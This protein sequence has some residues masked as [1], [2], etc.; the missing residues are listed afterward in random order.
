M[1]TLNAAGGFETPGGV[2]SASAGHRALGPLGLSLPVFVRAG[3]RWR[4]ANYREAV[5]G[6][7][8]KVE[9]ELIVASRLALAED[10]QQ[11]AV[12]A[13]VE[14]DRL[15]NR[16]YVEGAADD[17]EVVTAQTAELQARQTDIQIRTQRLMA[18]IDLVRA[19][20][21]GWSPGKAAAG[22]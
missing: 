15:A 21:G 7:F 2:T 1:I 18:S 16:R 11:E 10:R 14:T 12:A 6:A 13:A 3:A 19:L 20:G 22:E 9:D 17:L 4:A 8:R 5:L